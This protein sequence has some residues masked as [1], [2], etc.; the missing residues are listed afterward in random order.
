VYSW[1]KQSTKP[2]YS[3]SEVGLS[4]VDNTADSAKNVL[5]AL[6]AGGLSTP[7]AAA[8]GGT[9]LTASGANRNILKSNGTAWVSEAQIVSMTAQA[10]TSGTAIDFI[11]IPAGVRRITVIFVNV[12]SSGTSSWLIRLGSGSIDAAGYSGSSSYWS[13]GAFSFADATG[14]PLCQLQPSYTHSGWVSILNAGS[15]IWVASGLLGGA[16]PS[17]FCCTGAKTLSGALDR[18]RIT[19]VN[20]TDTFDAGSVNI[21]YE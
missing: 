3:K 21:L 10:A 14:F 13:G 6:T 2:S 15:N 18:L 5:S 4:N 9:G 8:S 20:G 1:A 19:T 17:G 7:L 12:S 11:N 16:V